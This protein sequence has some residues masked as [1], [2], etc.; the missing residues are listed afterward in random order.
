MENA[1][2]EV[3]YIV[4][5]NADMN[6]AVVNYIC[7]DGSSQKRGH[8]SVN[9]VVTGIPKEGKKTLDVQVF[10]RFCHP[11]SKWE[12]QKGTPEYEN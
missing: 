12:S 6:D 2:H 1:A 7:I 9:G 5:P 3:R 11:C 4:N 10:S 8:N